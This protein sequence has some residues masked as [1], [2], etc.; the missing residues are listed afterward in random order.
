MRLECFA[1]A[2]FVSVFLWQMHHPEIALHLVKADD[3]PVGSDGK[4]RVNSIG[5]RSS[6]KVLYRKRWTHG[7]FRHPVEP[8]GPKAEKTR[9][10]PVGSE[11]HR[12]AVTRPSRI[13]IEMLQ[14]RE[15]GPPARIHRNILVGGSN[16]ELFEL[17]CQSRSRLKNNPAPI[18]RQVGCE[19]KRAGLLCQDGLPSTYGLDSIDANTQ[20]TSALPAMFCCET[21]TA[22][23]EDQDRS[24]P[25]SSQTFRELRRSLP[26]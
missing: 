21:I 5:A 12:L 10:I 7:P 23:L 20:S 1:S 24:W 2:W 11:I 17:A 19:Q 25:Q 15:S 18:G 22:P 16:E 4:C 14:V 9:P 6:M 3:D 8:K 26:L 13:C